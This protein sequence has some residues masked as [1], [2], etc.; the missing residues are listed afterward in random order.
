MTPSL[1]ADRLDLDA[2]YMRQLCTQ[3]RDAGYIKPVEPASINSGLYELTTEGQSEYASA[4]VND[5][6]EEVERLSE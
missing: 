2:N 6:L 1:I 4:A 3:I 5:M